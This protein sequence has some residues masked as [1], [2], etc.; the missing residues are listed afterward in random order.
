MKGKNKKRMSRLK[1]RKRE[2]RK[3]RGK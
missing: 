1:H 3:R 2:Q